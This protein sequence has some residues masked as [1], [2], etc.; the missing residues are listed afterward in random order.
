MY[1]NI[2]SESFTVPVNC[3]NISQKKEYVIDAVK[4]KKLQEGE[5]IVKQLIIMGTLLKSLSDI[6]SSVEMG[7]ALQDPEEL[8]REC[9]DLSI[10]ANSYT[11]DQF[12]WRTP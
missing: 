5:E 4:Q 1:R 3:C 11:A 9:T 8:H 10:N 7:N 6:S 2:V 12:T